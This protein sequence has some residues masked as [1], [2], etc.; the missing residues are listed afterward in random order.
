MGNHQ[1]MSFQPLLLKHIVKHSGATGA[2]V[3]GM[4]LFRNSSVRFLTD[5]VR[6]WPFHLYQ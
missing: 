2:L 1:I 6:C 5:A 3:R 4:E